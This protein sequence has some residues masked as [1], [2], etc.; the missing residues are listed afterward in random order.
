[1]TEQ[2]HNKNILTLHHFLS[3]KIVQMEISFDG[4]L[5]QIGMTYLEKCLIHLASLSC[6]AAK[7]AKLKIDSIIKVI[8]KDH[9]KE[10]LPPIMIP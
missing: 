8:T 4:H 3:L 10:T 5:A 6:I 1:M 9:F 7:N 2:V